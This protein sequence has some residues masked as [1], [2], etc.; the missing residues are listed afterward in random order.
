MIDRISPA[1]HPFYKK[2][3]RSKWRSTLLESTGKYMIT[4]ES[5]LE[6]S[7]KHKREANINQSKTGSL[8]RRQTTSNRNTGKDSNRSTVQPSIV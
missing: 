4:Q 5:I 2:L 3:K 8:Q 1:N 6:N 7:Y